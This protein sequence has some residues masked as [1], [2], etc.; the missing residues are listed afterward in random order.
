MPSI[1]PG[2]L[3]LRMVLVLGIGAPFTAPLLV[4]YV[5]ERSRGIAAAWQGV[6]AGCGAIF[7]VFVLFFPFAESTYFFKFAMPAVVFGGFAVIIL[8]LVSD[9]GFYESKKARAKEH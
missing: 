8:F 4:D 7:S 9:V 1:F 2:L 6:A 3:L 5:K